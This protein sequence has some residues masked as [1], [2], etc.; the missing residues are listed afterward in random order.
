MGFTLILPWQRPWKCTFFFCIILALTLTSYSSRRLARLGSMSRHLRSSAAPG[1]AGKTALGCDEPGTH[2]SQR[3]VCPTGL[4][5]WAYSYRSLLRRDP[6]TPTELGRGRGWSAVLLPALDAGRLT[7]EHRAG[8][9]PGRDP[10][11]PGSDASNLPPATGPFISCCIFVLQRGRTWGRLFAPGVHLSADLAGVWG[12]HSPVGQALGQ[13]GLSLASAEAT[14][15]RTA[16]LPCCV[17][18]TCQQTSP[19]APTC[20]EHLLARGARV[21]AVVRRDGAIP[22]EGKQPETGG[23]GQNRAQ[24]KKGK[25]R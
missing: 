19:R 17:V 24:L 20:Q 8:T 7:S 18:L 21:L 22:A 25:Q 3:G 13:C 16:A 23:M 14:H 6:P 5:F 4:L 11:A 1:G 9:S 10:A 2:A 15:G 12:G